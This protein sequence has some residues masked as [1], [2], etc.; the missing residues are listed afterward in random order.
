MKKLT[1]LSMDDESKSIGSDY[2]IKGLN[3]VEYE[4]IV[5]KIEVKFSLWSA[6]KMRIAGINNINSPEELSQDQI[7]AALPHAYRNEKIKE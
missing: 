5:L 4:K 1:F 7:N 6:I 3:K 2:Q